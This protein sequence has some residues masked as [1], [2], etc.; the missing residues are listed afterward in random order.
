MGPHSRKVIP[1]LEKS[2]I[3]L[4]GDRKAEADMLMGG[5]CNDALS[6]GTDRDELQG[7]S[8]VATT[9]NGVAG[10]VIGQTSS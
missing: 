8:G 3:N 1:V 7:G 5:V 4:S 2:D 9:T 6:S 10:T